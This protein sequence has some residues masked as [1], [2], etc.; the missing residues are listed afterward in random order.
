MNKPVI[1]ITIP[2]V[3]NDIFY[4]QKKGYPE[5]VRLNGGEALLIPTEEDCSNI[6]QIVSMID[7]LLVPGGADIEPSFYREERLPEC[8]KASLTDD[9]YDMEII[10]EAVRQGKPILGICRGHQLINVIYGGTLYQDIPTQY[11]TDIEHRMHPDH[12]ETYH[13]ADIDPDSRIGR[14]LGKGHLTVNSSHHQSVKEV[15]KGFKVVGKAPD[16]IVEAM[17]NEDGSIL[18]V[19]WHPER[20]QNEECMRNLVKDLV[21]RSRQ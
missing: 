1:G 20:M 2:H 9:R 5:A 8:G 4:M 11:K 10:R 12:T 16:G 7:G 13:E 6:P 19:Q 17:E 18:T 3:F 14:I 15:G 21:E